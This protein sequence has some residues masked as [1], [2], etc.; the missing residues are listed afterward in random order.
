MQGR[1]AARRVI[2]FPIEPI[3]I[4]LINN[5]TIFIIMSFGEFKN[6]YINFRKFMILTLCILHYEKRKRTKFQFSWSITVFSEIILT[7][8]I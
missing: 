8:S 3:Y 6:F 7:S 1:A 4:L 5:L 2:R